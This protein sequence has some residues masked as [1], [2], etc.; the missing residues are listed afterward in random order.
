[1]PDYDAEIDVLADVPIDEGEVQ[2]GKSDSLLAE[3]RYTTSPEDTITRTA[4]TRDGRRPYASVFGVVNGPEPGRIGFRFS[5]IR[6]NR[7]IDGVD[8]GKPDSMFK[9]YCKLVDLYAQ[10]YPGEKPKKVTDLYHFVTTMPLQ[11]RVIKNR[12]GDDNMVVNISLPREG[13]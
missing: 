11:Y 2:K 10:A 7:A 3:G 13:A 8:T 6:Q 5:W 9:N 1:M 12:E 4:Q